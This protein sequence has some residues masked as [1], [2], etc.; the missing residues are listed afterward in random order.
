LVEPKRLKGKN[1]LISDTIVLDQERCVVCWRCI[2]Y[3]EE[4]EDKPQL[5]LFERG[6]KTIIDIQDGT[7]VDA[8]TSGNI[9][10]ICPVGALTNRVARFSF[11][12]WE[13][14]RTPSICTHCSLGCNLRIDTRTHKLRRV[15]G[16][17]NMQ[18]NDQ[19]L[20]DKG[21][22]ANAWVNDEGRLTMPLVRK[23]GELT[24]APWGEALALVAE[25]LQ[26]IKQQHGADAIGGIGSAKLSNESNYLLQRFM[27]QLIGTNNIDHRDGGD[28]GCAAH[29]HARPGRCDEAAVWAESQARRGHARRRRSERRNAG[30]RRASEAGGA[31][32][33]GA[34]RDRPPAPDRVD[35]LQW[36]VPAGESGHG[37]HAAQRSAAGAD[38]SQRGHRHPTRTS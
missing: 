8:K 15:I 29:R 16:R 33:Q 9:I 26:A 7:P 34:A 21:R 12:P 37:S 1:H 31:A 4:W 5:A 27:R 2:R 25:K 36:P 14:E 3:L 18:V 17:E 22:F 24:P 32:R 30:A 20:C 35:A 6:G 10:D 13:I 28:D 38:H 19:W 11:R 23:H